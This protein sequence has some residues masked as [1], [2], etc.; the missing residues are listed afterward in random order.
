MKLH[1]N[2]GLT[3]KG[4][5]LLVDR[6]LA[7][8]CRRRRSLRPQGS[9]NERPAGSLVFAKRASKACLIGPTESS[10]SCRSGPADGVCDKV[11]W[12]SARAKS[13]PCGAHGPWIERL[14]RT[15]RNEDLV[16]L[17]RLG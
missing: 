3:L 11:G 6:V 7:Q 14:Q 16:R 1:A 17:R 8:G 10:P 9:V 15:L 2:A 13:P 5:R 4:R 12:R